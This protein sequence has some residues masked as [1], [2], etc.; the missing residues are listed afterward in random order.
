MTDRIDKHKAELQQLALEITTLQTRF[1]QTP[2]DP[3]AL[4]RIETQL[5]K[6]EVQLQEAQQ[7]IGAQQQKIDDLKDALEK[8]EALGNELG[9]AQ[10]ELERWQRLQETIPANVLRD[11]ALE[12]MFKAD[13]QFGK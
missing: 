5:E 7:E 4:D 6:I 12:I 2:Y 13:G 11:F 9:A 8:R 10:Q 1:E 3:D